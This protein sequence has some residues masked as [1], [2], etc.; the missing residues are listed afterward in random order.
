ML[1]T[2][3]GIF[4]IVGL[5]VESLYREDYEWNK[6]EVVGIAMSQLGIALMITSIGILIWR[7]MP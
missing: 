5:I 6:I 7:Y 2:I 3:G 1:F 4:L